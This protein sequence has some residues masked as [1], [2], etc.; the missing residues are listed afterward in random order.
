MNQVLVP[1]AIGTGFYAVG[2][3]Y[4]LGWLT[5]ST[6]HLIVAATGIGYATVGTLSLLRMDYN[7]ALI[8]LGYSIGQVGLYRNI[9]K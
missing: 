8:W 5:V 1:F 6:S 2:I 9:P 7:N 3:M 4:W